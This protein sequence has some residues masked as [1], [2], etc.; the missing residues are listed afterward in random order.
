ME[1]VVQEGSPESR[2]TTGSRDARWERLFAAHTPEAA[3]HEISAWFGDPGPLELAVE[4]PGGLVARSAR[5]GPRPVRHRSEGRAEVAGCPP[6]LLRASW[7]G[8]E[9]EAARLTG[10]AATLLE[11]WRACR[12]ERE[13]LSGRLEARTRELALFQSLSRAAAE[14]RDVASLLTAAARILRQRAGAE[15]VAILHSFE[16]GPEI[17]AFVPDGGSAAELPSLLGGASGLPGWG[18][19]AQPRLVVRPLGRVEA[20]SWRG[21]LAEPLRA[22]LSRRGRTV[23]I[24]AVL[25]PAS[26]GRVLRRVLEVAANELSLNL[27]RILTVRESEQ[28]RFRAMLDSM[29]QAVLLTDASLRILEANPAARSWLGR[30]GAAAVGRLERVGDVELPPLAREAVD[31]APAGALARFDDGTRM[32]VSLSALRAGE[33]GELVIVLSDVTEQQRMQEQLAQAEKLSSLGRM[34]SGVAHELN[35]PLTAILGHSELALAELGDDPLACRA[36]LVR[37]EARRC[38]RIVQTLLRFARRQDPERKPVA[39]S[40]VVQAV[41]ALAGS[42]LR[43]DGIEVRTEIDP[44]VPAVLGDA[45]ELQQVLVNLLVNA[46]QAIR[47]AGKGGAVAIR[48]F[49]GGEGGAV[50]DVEDDGPGIPESI[51]SRIFDP[52]FT[53]KSPGTG[54]G[55]GLW[56]VYGTVVAHGG[57]VRVESEEGRGARFRIELPAAPGPPAGAERREDGPPARPAEAA[58][59]RVLVVEESEPVARFLCD[60]LAADGHA[61][62]WEPEAGAAVERVRRDGFDLVLCDAEMRAPDGG[63]LGAAFELARPGLSTRVL[64]TAT[65]EAACRAGGP[66]LLRK[67]F[68]LAEVRR[69]VRARLGAGA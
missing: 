49:R 9:G 45:H 51:R 18:P 53:T 34:I 69:L 27:D 43:A 19:Q 17:L 37:D 31:G 58:R 4:G 23:A 24:L 42:Q 30:L 52:F 2:A 20:G 29:P 60:A 25:S 11:A 5:A 39:L 3:L 21:R 38:Q 67:P 62:A 22:R 50:L 61:C 15:I 35:N 63:D 6:W 59:A 8:T 7:G 10:R 14:A 64:W 36:R 33:L 13:R 47:E 40:E 66:A 1:L 41:L 16:G 57:A 65:G 32:A 28:L 44:D 12:A 54:T 55:L 48:A 26:E 46:Q 56:L 68:D